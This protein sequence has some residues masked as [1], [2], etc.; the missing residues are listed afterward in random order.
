MNKSPVRVAVDL[1]PVL[2][3]GENGGAKIF[4]LDLL[5]QLADMAPETQFILLTQAASHDE[6]ASLD[7]ANVQRRMVI[8]PVSPNSARPRLKQLASRIGPRIPGRLRRVVGRVGYRLNVRLKRREASALLRNLGVDLLF[9]PF[10]APTYFEPGI[11]T[12]CTIYDLQ[13]KTY[14]EFFAPEDVAHRAQTFLEASRRAT[15]LAAIS[16]YSRQSAIEHGGLDPS[17]IRTI[18]LRMARRIAP[19][20]DQSTD[21]LDRLGI[22]SHQYLIYPANFWKHKNHEMLLTA[23]GMAVGKGLAAD[24]KLVCTGAPGVR[25][26]WLRNAAH[27]MR[28]GDRIVFPGYLPNSELATLMSHSRGV[29]FPSLY[30]GFGLPVIEAMT[31]GV[32][33]ACSNTTSLPEVA[34]D[35]AILFDP[36]VPDQ[37]ANAMMTL[38]NDETL[39]TRLAAAGQQRAEEFADS[40]RMANEYWELFQHALA[41]TRQENLITGVAVDGWIGE[42]LKIQVAPLQGARRLEIELMAPDWL[43]QRSIAVQVIRNG[44]ADGAPIKLKRAATAVVS[45][46]IDEAGGYCELQLSPT[47]V[48]A[49]LGLGDDQRELSAMLKRCS[50]LANNS[51]SLQLFPEK[52]SA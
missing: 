11:P 18:Y 26:E 21:V 51:L 14:P 19:Q 7:R 47:F 17:R 20:T 8:G 35:A 49:R 30:E 25:Q 2:P 31:A 33:V 12:V 36:R 45:L 37:I 13:Y 43:P 27:D 15:A 16:E 38:V 23:F 6:L 46:P 28:L 24:I 50:I 1:T 29:V 10:T 3:G 9:C 34:A 5:R 44:K 41:D 52:T 22:A 39:R 4:V 40:Q 42:G 48:P 32:P